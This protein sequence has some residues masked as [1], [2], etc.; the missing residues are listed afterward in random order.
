MAKRYIIVER[1]GPKHCPHCIP[2]S[3]RKQNY[4][5]LRQMKS[6]D[7]IDNRVKTFPRFCPLNKAENLNNTQQA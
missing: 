6:G 2:D 7:V 3:W 4:C 5:G 1:C